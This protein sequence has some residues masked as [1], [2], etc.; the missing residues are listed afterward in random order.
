MRIATSAILAASLIAAPAMAQK[1]DAPNRYAT[2][3]FVAN[4][5][6]YKPTLNVEKKFINAWGLAIRPA[7]AGGH[8][9]VTAKD[10]SYEYVGDVQQSPDPTLRVMHQDALKIVT[11]PV[12]GDDKF[13][14]STVFNDN[15]DAFVITQAVKGKEPITSGAKFL[16]AS[17]GGIISAWTERKN[18]D[19]TVDHPPVA[20][21]VI[22]LSAKGVQFFGLAI[23]AENDRLYAADFG[24]KPGILVFDATFKPEDVRF[25][26]PFDENKNGMVDAGEYAPFNVQALTTPAGKSRIFVTY[27]KTQACPSAEVKKGHARKVLFLLVKKISASPAMAVLRNLPR[28][29]N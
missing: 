27:A 7:G 18:A 25:D 14:T 1:I 23:N 22:D 11:L 15:K 16:F 26:M 24:E 21:N 2:E 20:N 6:K 5:A 29:A 8:F 17:D 13:S 19:G 9:W 4:K 12:G 3:I 10:V 28:M